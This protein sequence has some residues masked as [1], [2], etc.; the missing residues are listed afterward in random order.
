MGRTLVSRHFV[1]VILASAAR[2]GGFC[3]PAL[4]QQVIADAIAAIDRVSAI[5]VIARRYQMG[6]I[7]IPVHDYRA[8]SGA[9][10]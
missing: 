9:V 10:F 6:A 5:V 7:A 2:C 8:D 4:E 3:Q 1:R